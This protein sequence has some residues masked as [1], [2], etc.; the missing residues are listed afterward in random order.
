MRVCYLGPNSGN[1]DEGMKVTLVNLRNAIEQHGVSTLTLE[2]TS[3]F[4]RTYWSE[5]REFDPDIIHY[6]PGP[7]SKSLILGTMT[8]T[9]ANASLVQSTPLPMLGAVG[10][11]LLTV[12]KP[13]YAFVQSDRTEKLFQQKGVRTEF[14]PTGVDLK[15]FRPVNAEA[16]DETRKKLGISDTKKIILHVGHLKRDR[17]IGIFKK[18]QQVENIQTL[19]IGSST[20]ETDENL[21]RE[22][23][24]AGCIVIDRY[25]PNIEQYYGAADVYMFPTT[26]QTDSI[27]TPAS[28]MEALACNL[29]VVSTLFGALPRLF[30]H[31]G[32][33][34][35]FVEE[36]QLVEVTVHVANS[37]QAYDTRQLIE[38]YSWD[39]L[40]EQVI[41]IYN[42][43]S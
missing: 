16:R 13:D 26:S 8:K 35:E 3:C 30:D 11:A 43:V 10:K 15:V 9:V 38:E 28:V 4:G 27:E 32:D 18:V 24:N 41:E 12:L 31:T 7:S 36:N 6:V 23:E 39:R 25:L 21:T 29:P 40:A 20:T 17:N 22:L 5:L 19:L 14:L 33:G 42:D 1:I 2:P 37:D 34:I